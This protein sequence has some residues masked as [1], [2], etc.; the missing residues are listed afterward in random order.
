MKN[1]LVLLLLLCV[2][3]LLA[4]A[5]GVSLHGKITDKKSGEPVQGAQVALKSDASKIVLTNDSGRFTIHVPVSPATLVVSSL[6]YKD[7]EITVAAGDDV[8]VGLEPDGGGTLDEVVVVGAVMKKGSLTGAVASINADKI[9]ATPTS[10]LN[11][12]IQG[13]LPGA[14]I[15]SSPSPGADASIKVRGNNSIQFGTNP[16]YVV[17]GVIIENNF[18]VLNPDDIASVEVLKDA[19]ATAIYGSRG[20]NGVVIVTTKKGK[21]GTGT[22]T[23]NTWVGWQKFSKKMKMLGTHDLYNLRVDAFANQYMEQNPNGN[24]QAYINYI[25]SDSGNVFA[26]Y[27]QE[28]YRQNKTYNWLDAVSQTGMQQNHTLSFS[29]GSDKGTYLLSVNYTDQE[30]LIKGSDYKRFGGRLNLDQNIK[31]WLKI[32]TNTTFNRAV[33]EV[34]DGSVFNAAVYANPMLAIDSSLTYL[35]WADIVDQNAYNPLKS[36][37]LIS[38]NYLNRLLTSNYVSIS[39]G[40][41]FTLRS[42]FSADLMTQQNYAYIPSNTGQSI[43]NNDQGHA[44]HYKAENTNWQW[45]N[46]LTYTKRFGKHNLTALV[47][48][49]TQQNNSNYDQIDAYGFPN[50]DFTYMYLGGAYS[51]D[52]FVLGSDFVTTTLN[53]YLA[54]ADYSFNNKYFATATI[55]Y[56]GSSKFGPNN[57]WGTFPSIALGWDMARE[58]FMSGISWLNALKWRAGFGIAGNQN[59]PNY[60][61][62]SLYRPVYTNGSYTYQS[63]GRQGNPNLKW[64]RQKQLNFG[65]DIALLNNRLTFT[66]DY[67]NI[68]N[69]NLL[70]QQ[71]LATTSG[72]TNTIANVG[73]LKNTGVEFNINYGILRKKDFQWNFTF[74]L[75]ADKN[76]ITRLYGNTTAIYNRGGY[77]NVEIQ[78]TGN[79]FLGASLNNIYSYKFEKIAQQ[80]DMD[81][82]Q[83]IDFGGRT[84]HPGD[85]IPV[86]KDGNK[87]INDNDR[88]VVGKTDPKFYGGFGTDL[89]YKGFSLNLFFNY[90]SGLK[91]ISSFYEG[92]INSAGMSV[93][94][95]DILNRWTPEHTNTNIPR[96]L[97]GIARFNV[98]DVD[99]GIQNASFL[100]LSTATLSYSLPQ[101]TAKTLFL[102]N[103]RVYVT[104]TNLLLFTKDKGYDPETGDGYPNF[105]SLVL[106][107]NISL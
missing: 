29:G 44:T 52:K 60:A 105:K 76:R 106:G 95:E 59:I 40:K 54:R 62:Y 45:D 92:M 27:E 81:K 13:K 16:I 64:E 98:S 100:R 37:S 18:N 86:D 72:F 94:H 88:Y 35:K 6:G 23:Y 79:L 31:P 104:G 74:N 96:A 71:T 4:R 69:D 48:T 25:T 91:R 63:D 15:T 28:A 101:K 99:L 66:A 61:I 58:H 107:L 68:V 38:N 42:T 57:R 56:D 7:Q 36:L 85:I 83:D 34:T 12:A 53:S 51:K 90:S 84:V 80:S 32:G 14:R 77:T 70:M 43:R 21:K 19:S 17:D 20:A 89:S 10:S 24:R 50:D 41:D 9:A 82:I 103:A 67:F 87:I 33:S 11:Q 1:R 8:T 78:R 22:I 93:A 47:G 55:R 39:L 5:Q 46:T 65:V 49:S 97:Y 26:P 75:S 30:G 73:A 3:C 2:P 102:N